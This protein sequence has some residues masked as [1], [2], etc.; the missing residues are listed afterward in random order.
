MRSGATRWTSRRNA[1]AGAT[2]LATATALGFAAMAPQATPP[3]EA[4]DLADGLPPPV[5][6]A[7]RPGAPRRLASTRHLSHWA[8]VER[9]A[10]VRAAPD[11]GARLLTMLSPWT[12]ERTR[13]IVTVLEHRLDAAGPTWVRVALAMLPNGSTGWVRRS[14]LGGYGTVE[15]QLVVDLRSLRATLY[16]RGQPILHAPVGVGSE[17]WPTP[18]GTYYVRSKLTRYRSPSYGPLAFGTSARSPAATGWPAGRFVG[19]HG[20]DRPDLL[21]G[22]ISHGCIRMRNAD[23]L[24]LERH[25]PVGTPI[26]IH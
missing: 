15:T 7:F 9:S 20:T 13:N 11:S 5:A 23:I 14:A 24:A 12:P 17:R 10:P 16:R 6:P 2:V 1:I 3:P 8:P 26:T 18:R 25:M 19:I 21:P 22:R 4:T